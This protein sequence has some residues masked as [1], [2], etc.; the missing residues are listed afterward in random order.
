MS[1]AWGIPCL[2]FRRLFSVLRRQSSC[3]WMIIVCSWLLDADKAMAASPWGSELVP[4][5]V[6]RRDSMLRIGLKST[7]IV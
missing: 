5:T 2:S 3:L 1:E 7:P 4:C 6:S